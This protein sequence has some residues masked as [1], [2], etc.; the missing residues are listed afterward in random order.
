MVRSAETVFGPKWIGQKN[1]KRRKAPENRRKAAD[2]PPDNRRLQNWQK[3]AWQKNGKSKWQKDGW[4]KD[5]PERG[6]EGGKGVFP[7]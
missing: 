2:E 7:V 4:Q 5:C 3:N 1:R 6:I